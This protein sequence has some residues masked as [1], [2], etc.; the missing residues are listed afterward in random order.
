MCIRPYH[1]ALRHGNIA[2]NDENH[3]LQVGHRNAWGGSA[4]GWAR[5][6]TPLSDST[7]AATSKQPVS[8]NGGRARSRV[9]PHSGGAHRIR[10]GAAAAC[11]AS[12]VATLRVPRYHRKNGETLRLCADPMRIL[13]DMRRS[14]MH[15]HARA[16]LARAAV[17]PSAHGHA[18]PVSH[19]IRACI[20]L[21]NSYPSCRPRPP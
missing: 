14:R 15:A 19:M 2:R 6:Q 13:S 7:T 8:R 1:D 16:N 4:C 20:G 11:A 3:C 21:P 10:A 5:I 9:P 12:L 17:R 18:P